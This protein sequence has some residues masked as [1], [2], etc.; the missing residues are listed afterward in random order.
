M[1]RFERSQRA[2]EPGWAELYFQSTFF[3]YLLW[4]LQGGG[5]VKSGLPRKNASGIG[6]NSSKRAGVKFFFDVCKKS[7]AFLNRVGVGFATV[8]GLKVAQSSLD[9]EALRGFQK[10]VWSESAKCG[11]WRILS[12]SDLLCLKQPFQITLHPN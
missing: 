10:L 5:R 12:V 9:G 6:E 8:Q 1:R 2:G 3:V 7:L 11:S 4:Y